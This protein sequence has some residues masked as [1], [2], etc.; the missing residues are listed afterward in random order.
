MLRLRIYLLFVIDRADRL[1]FIDNQWSLPG[2]PVVNT[3][4]TTCLENSC[5]GSFVRGIEYNNFEYV[6][7]FWFGQAYCCSD[8]FTI[9]TTEMCHFLHFWL[10]CLVEKSQIVFRL[11]RKCVI[12]AWHLCL[13]YDAGKFH[14]AK[15]CFSF[16]SVTALVFW[17]NVNVLFC[18]VQTIRYFCGGS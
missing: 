6:Q 4:V 14:F 13:H 11:A 10:Y 16:G 18:F 8:L 17:I 1:V 9:T 15:K 5:N 12:L 3:W 7:K 2:W